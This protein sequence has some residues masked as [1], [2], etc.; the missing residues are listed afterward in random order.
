M[1]GSVNN[2]IVFLDVDGTLLPF[3][4]RPAEPARPP[5]GRLLPADDAPGNPLL[6]RLDPADGP[7]LLALG[8]QL[9]WATTWMTDAND[10]IA[11]RLGLPQLPVVDFPDNGEPEHGSHW[12]TA[13]LARWAVSRPFVWL[14]DEI[15]DADRRWIQNHYPGKALLHRVEPSVGLADRD[16][17]HIREWLAEL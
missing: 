7:K 5:A 11:P 13:Y 14:D 1:A 2:P 4:A 9:V 15:T 16:F 17:D 3:R 8:C 12:K 6:E 10:L